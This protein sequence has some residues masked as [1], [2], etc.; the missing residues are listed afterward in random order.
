MARPSDPKEDRA[1]ERYQWIAPLL[2]AGLDAAKAHQLKEEISAQTGWSERTIRRYV[3][4]YRAQGWEGLK[5]QSKGPRRRDDVLSESLLEE[6]MILR[7]EVP[8][9]SITQLI[10][11]L[12]WEGRVAP[13][14]LKRSTLQ[15]R[16]AEKGYSAR[17]LRWQSASAVGSRR[18]QRRHRNALWQSDIKYGPYLPIGPKG[19]KKQVYLVAFLDDATRYVVYAG[20][21]PTL[22]QIIV[23]HALR[24]AITGYGVPEAVYFDNGSQ[25]TTKQMHRICTKLG[26]QLLYAKPYSPESKGKIERFNQSLDAF[27]TE[28]ALDQPATVDRLNALLQAWLSECYHTQP[29]TGLDPVRTPA[30]AYRED[31]QPIRWAEADQVTR[32]FLSARTSKVNK[33]GGISFQGTQ[34]YVGTTWAGQTVEVVYDPT[35][36][37]TVS[38]EVPGVEPWTARPMVIP[39]YNGIH[40]AKPPAKASRADQGPSRLLAGAQ[41]QQAARQERKQPALAYRQVWAEPAAPSP[42]APPQPE[43][44]D[45]ED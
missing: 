29:H 39:E 2:A 33:V 12:E 35:D 5:P 31:A 20:F 18:F 13:G 17:Q 1:I 3:A 40:R 6:A 25:Y 11:I 24:Q 41:K 30:V 19:A 27:L 22:D 14:Q 4:R 9:R 28:A 16:L 32:A 8:R 21:Y 45:H 7:R 15:A 34:Y 43:D 10:Q 37:S 38:I 23:E 44:S 42:E 36:L 26:I